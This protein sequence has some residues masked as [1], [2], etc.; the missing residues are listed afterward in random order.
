[1]KQLT[2]AAVLAA[3]SFST[4]D[5]ATLSFETAIAS[6]RL[7]PNRNAAATDYKVTNLGAQPNAAD[8]R[9]EINGF[10]T[11]L[12]A[13]AEVKSFA[14]TIGGTRPVVGKLENVSSGF[15]KQSDF[16]VNSD[17]FVSAPCL[18]NPTA[19][20][21]PPKSE[22][23]TNFVF[24]FSTDEDAVLNFRGFYD[25]G[26]STRH[27]SD[28]QTNLMI[29]NA[30]RSR[31]VFYSGSSNPNFT[32]NIFDET[33]GFFDG[34]INVE[35][36]ITYRFSLFQAASA[37]GGPPGVEIT[38]SAK[39]L[40]AANVNGEPIDLLAFQ[41]RLEAQIAGVAPVPLPA[42]GWLM[43]AGMGGLGA[44]RCRKKTIH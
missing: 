43:L 19:G 29:T 42:A 36:G 30:N 38:D 37:V 33:F 23:E 21:C 26:S 2:F 18:K 6:S 25:R 7:N 27:I 8:R 35:A 1:M 44:L 28:D 4:A 13:Q 3:L 34:A 31:E 15:F 41:S 32:N 40:F 39:F 12:V 17:I 24:D 10:E 16:F 20:T 22:A 11:G 5:A 14:H 9:V